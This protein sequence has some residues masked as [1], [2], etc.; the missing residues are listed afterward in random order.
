MSMHHGSPQAARMPLPHY[1]RLRDPM[2]REYL[3]SIVQDQTGA[4]VHRFTGFVWDRYVVDHPINPLPP[5]WWEAGPWL[6]TH[7]WEAACPA[8]PVEKLAQLVEADHGDMVRECLNRAEYQQ[9]AVAPGPELSG[10][11]AFFRA[12]ANNRPSAV[13]ALVAHRVDP[14]TEAYYGITP[15][16]AVEL[17]LHQFKSGVSNFGVVSFLIA[18][19]DIEP[20]DVFAFDKAAEPYR[21]MA[22][23]FRFVGLSQC[24]DAIARAVEHQNRRRGRGPRW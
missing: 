24:L 10:W 22:P 2:G 20:A 17:A 6:E 4:P 23:A 1:R 8:L 15:T 11:P 18:H 16:N 14:Y 9:V 12:V 13:G 7:L 21:Q 19:K 5:R 3:V